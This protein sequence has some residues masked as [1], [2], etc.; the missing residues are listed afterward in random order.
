MPLEGSSSA[1]VTI[2]LY[3]NLH[4]LSFP[5]PVPHITEEYHRKEGT[6]TIFQPLCTFSKVIFLFINLLFDFGWAGCSLLN[7]DFL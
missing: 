1:E 3:P 7:V 4:L 6:E 5:E 2:N